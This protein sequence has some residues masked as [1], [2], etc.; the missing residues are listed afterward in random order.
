MKIKSYFADSVEAAVAQARTELGS[1]AMLINSRRNPE[2]A[3]GA[4]KYEVVFG[5]VA[6]GPRA[7]P[8]PPPQ[9]APLAEL[10]E[11]RKQISELQNALAAA[12]TPAKTVSEQSELKSWDD[13]LRAADLSS[14]VV[15]ELLE[16]V[17]ARLRS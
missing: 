12:K 5:V 13:R 7:K 17:L 3:A 4:G 6:E 9:P 16:H 10:S 1:E 11:I 15:D 8:A 14:E 2:T